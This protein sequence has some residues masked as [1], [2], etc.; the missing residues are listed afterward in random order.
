M[1]PDEWG[2]WYPLR[3]ALCYM[4]MSESTAMRTELRRV[5]EGGGILERYGNGITQKLI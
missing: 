2:E 3:G 4:S 5:P 1:E